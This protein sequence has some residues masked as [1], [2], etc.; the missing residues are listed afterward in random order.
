[1]VLHNDVAVERQSLLSLQETKG[2]QQECY[3]FWLA[4]Y[5]HPLDGGAGDEVRLRTEDSVAGSGHE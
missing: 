1:M 3:E 2:V 4:E 5:G